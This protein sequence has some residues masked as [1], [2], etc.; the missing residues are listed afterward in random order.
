VSDQDVGR[1]RSEDRSKFR[2][3]HPDSIGRRTADSFDGEFGDLLSLSR[4]ELLGTAFRERNLADSLARDALAHASGTYRHLIRLTRFDLV[5]RMIHF[6]ASENGKINLERLSV[7]VRQLG[8]E[9]ARHH[10]SE[11]LRS[12]MT[13][14]DE[15]G[16]ADFD[17]I[18]RKATANEMIRISRTAARGA[19]IYAALAIL[20]R[21]DEPEL[22]NRRAIAVFDRALGRLKP[23]VRAWVLTAAEANMTDEEIRTAE[24]LGHAE[25][26]ELFGH[27]NDVQWVSKS[28]SDAKRKLE[29]TRRHIFG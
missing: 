19:A 23:I 4:Y 21:S 20:A 5:D 22:I 18:R 2:S 12:A 24:F 29:K 9:E 16:L 26:A 3:P 10:A 25:L 28:V 6:Q 11:I 17:R 27:S 13:K 1:P 7:P 8:R 15:P 14:M